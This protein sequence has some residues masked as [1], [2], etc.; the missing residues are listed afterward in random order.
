VDLAPFHAWIV[1]AHVVGVILFLLA[2]GVSAGVLWRLQ[3]EREPAAVRTLLDLSRRSM[4]AMSIG[5][6]IWFA[7]GILAGF[8]GNYWT[9]GKYWIWASLVIAF[10]IV[11][12][13]TPFGRIYLNRVREV[14][15]IDTKSGVID[16]SKPV[17]P[18]A[19]EAAIK[20]GQ[21]MLLLAVGVLG[22]I[23]LAYL[24]MFKPF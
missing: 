1:F 10:V 22:L 21:P 14:V 3:G 13:M 15:G 23:V 5:A 2:H 12:L 11:G 9:T 7:A 24:M 20:S 19:L 16:A 6:L 8:S 18:V 17:D 4:I